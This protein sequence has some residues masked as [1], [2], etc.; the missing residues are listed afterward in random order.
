MK[1]NKDFIKFLFSL[2][3]P[4]KVLAIVMVVSMMISQVFDLVKQYIIKGII[5]LPSNPNF[6]VS[7]LYSVAFVLIIIIILQ[8]IFFYI[9]NITRTIFVVKKQ[10]PYIAE[11][12]FNVLDK[13]NYAFFTDNYS[14][15]ISSSINEVNDEIVNLNTRITTGFMSL[16]TSMISSLIILY[17]INFYIFITAF[18]LFAGIIITR[19]VYF[20]YKYL[21]LIKNAQETNREY[22]GVLND[23][24]LNFTSLKIYNAVK[25]FSENLRTKKEEVNVYKNEASTRE[26]TYG[27]IANVA[28]VLVFSILIIYSISLFNKGLMTLGDFVFF[29]N[30][31]IS[32][33]TASTS[34]TWSYIHIGEI[35]VKVKNS[36]DLLFNDNNLKND[37]KKDIMINK[38]DIVLNNVSFKYKRSN[39]LENF[40]LTIKDKEKVGIIGVSGSG[41]TTFVNL[42]FKFYTPQKG[43]I[44]IDNKN[45]NDYNTSLYMKI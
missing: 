13:K 7:D 32:I 36:Y 35:L 9:S 29:I 45:I 28:Y 6:Q 22:N 4:V 20:S 8:L 43:E 12:L 17:T 18:I 21:P 30:A 38:G 11:Y 1:K 44:L 31:M 39:V 34:F 14:G 24:V 5:D 27:A 40:N 15:K 25:T 16:L 33:K 37:N 41:K 3:K 26:F 42:L 23:A 19:I 2:Y 10:T